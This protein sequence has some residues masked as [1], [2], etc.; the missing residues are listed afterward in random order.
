VSISTTLNDPKTK[1]FSGFSRFRAATHI[2]RVNCAKMAEDDKVMLSD[3]ILFAFVYFSHSLF[4]LS[5]CFPT[6]SCIIPMAKAK[7][8][9]QKLSAQ[10]PALRIRQQ[11]RHNCGQ[12]SW[13][14]RHR[15]LARVDAETVNR[16]LVTVRP[17]RAIE[18]ARQ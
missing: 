15:R 3:S 11:M 2:L 1:G 8:L 7:L 13:S 16:R 18:R 14:C 4:H 6:H 5:L 10:S 9:K 17:E 12:R